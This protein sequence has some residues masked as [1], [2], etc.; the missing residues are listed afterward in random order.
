MD[1]DGGGTERSMTEKSLDSHEIHTIF[2]EMST[3]SMTEGMAGETVRPAEAL[4]VIK[5]MTRDI[6]S[7][8]RTIFLSDLREK[9]VHGP[10][11]F[12]PVLGKDLESIFRQ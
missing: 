3:E 10:A 8:H 5:N 9:P 4:F 6:E 2:I 1:I 11:A 12:P 7:I